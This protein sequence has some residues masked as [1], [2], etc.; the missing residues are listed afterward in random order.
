MKLNINTDLTNKGSHEAQRS[1]RFGRPWRAKRLIRRFGA[2]P[3]AERPAAPPVLDERCAPAP[4]LSRRGA[5]VAIDHARRPGRRPEGP[6][7]RWKA[8]TGEIQPR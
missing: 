1:R 6:R 4:P 5:R 2:F 7:R 3:R 8:P